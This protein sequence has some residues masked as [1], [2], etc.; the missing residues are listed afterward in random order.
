MS[1]EPVTLALL[2]GLDANLKG[3]FLDPKER[4]QANAVG[5]AATTGLAH[6]SPLSAFDA[7]LGALASE[8][9]TPLA[10]I[11]REGWK[12]DKQLRDAVESGRKHGAAQGEVALHKH[13]ITATLEPTAEVL[14]N[15]IPGPAIRFE[16]KLSVVIEGLLLVIRDATIAGIRAGTITAKLDLNYLSGAGASTVR[17]PLMATRTTKLSADTEF[18][19]PFGGIRIV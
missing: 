18:P 5:A 14:V 4:E 13:T 8:L 16:V 2:A 11:L 1:D 9:R 15:K 10:D 7:L 19:L 12:Q 3:A 6:A 17:M